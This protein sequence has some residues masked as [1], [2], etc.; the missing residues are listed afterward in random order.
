MSS[1]EQ[2]H[3]PRRLGIGFFTLSE[4]PLLLLFRLPKV[5]LELLRDL[6]SWKAIL[7]GLVS[8]PRRKMFQEDDFLARLLVRVVV[9]C[10]RIFG[11]GLGWEWNRL[12]GGFLEL[13]AEVVEELPLLDD[14]MLL[15]RLVMT[16]EEE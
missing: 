7:G 12:R 4:P 5:F 15:L 14:L 10:W 2:L 16:V 11:E 3:P 13:A 6:I 8:N 9:P 1:R